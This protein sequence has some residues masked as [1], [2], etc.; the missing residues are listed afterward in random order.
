MS[1]ISKALERAE[2]DRLK[3]RE[4]VSGAPVSE[5][6]AV[7][8]APEPTPRAAS[9]AVL[10]APPVPPAE[11]IQEMS[12]DERVLALFDPRSMVAE[13]QPWGNDR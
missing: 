10:E 4:P 3:R 2:I 9:V 7:A 5:R 12:V 8:A 11:T 6:T 13:Q 1:R